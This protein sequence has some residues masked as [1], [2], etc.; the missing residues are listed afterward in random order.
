MVAAL[1]CTAGWAQAPADYP[2]RPITIVAPTVPGGG[3]ESELRL[4][5]Q[6]VT[7]TTGIQFV[8]IHK[9][10]AGG[11]IAADFVAKSKPDGYT[12]LIGEGNL[13]SAPVLL[14]SLP[15]DPMRD[16]APVTILSRRNTMLLVKESLAAK[17][18]REY[19]AYAKAHPGKVNFASVSA[20]NRLAAELLHKLA[21]VKVT[22]VDYKGT[23][24]AMV[25]LLAGRVDGVLLS[26]Q[27]SIQHVRAGKLKAL[28]MGTAERSKHF[29]DL[30]TIAEQGAPGYRYY[31]WVG[32]I[33]PAGTPTAVLDKLHRELALAAQEPGLRKRLEADAVDILA[34]TPKEASEFVRSEMELWR[35]AAGK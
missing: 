32:L 11:T 12:L 25:D 26:P 8:I 27:A 2:S 22:I 23:A 7:E 6:R 19:F 5:L 4:Y 24:E 29:P 20:G 17:N 35:S 14:K 33:A 21:D 30:M 16:F 34:S 31:S 1:A 28:G 15:F 13:T 9:P 3:A 10:G 18:A